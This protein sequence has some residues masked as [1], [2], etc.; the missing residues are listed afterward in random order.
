ML[1]LFTKYTIVVWNI[2][3]QGAKDVP[4]P[5]VLTNQLE[6]TDLFLRGSFIKTSDNIYRSRP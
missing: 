5:A 4:D 6:H 3:Y 2:H 1:L